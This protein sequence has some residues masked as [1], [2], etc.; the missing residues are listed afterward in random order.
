M[1]HAHHA[2]M[3]PCFGGPSSTKL[4]AVGLSGMPPLL[5]EFCRAAHKKD[6]VRSFKKINK[7]QPLAP[8]C[9]A[10]ILRFVSDVLLLELPK[11]VQPS[12]TSRTIA[13]RTVGRSFGHSTMF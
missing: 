2:G 12:E 5:L 8:R 4:L 11:L 13:S 10:Q 3:F 9:A 7:K 6:F 1:S